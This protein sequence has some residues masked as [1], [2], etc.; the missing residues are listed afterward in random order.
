LDQSVEFILANYPHYR[1]SR[2]LQMQMEHFVNES[3]STDPH[4]VA[5]TL[6]LSAILAGETT[7]RRIPA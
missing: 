6:M 2:Y 4:V 1:D 3:D 7:P 5:V